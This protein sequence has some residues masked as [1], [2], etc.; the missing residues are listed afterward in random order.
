MQATI[1]QKLS[2]SS[3]IKPKKSGNPSQPKSTNLSKNSN[4]KSSNS[5]GKSQPTIN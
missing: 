2:L 4:V 3:Q 5:K 1:K